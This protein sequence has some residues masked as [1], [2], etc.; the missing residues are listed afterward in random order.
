MKKQKKAINI[1]VEGFNVIVITDKGV[2]TKKAM[3]NIKKA[4]E[5]LKYKEGRVN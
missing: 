3:E 5:E 1:T 2:I 4:L